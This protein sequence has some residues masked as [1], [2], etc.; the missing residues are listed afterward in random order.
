M[1]VV[2]DFKRERLRLERTRG[3]ISSSSSSSLSRC[4]GTEP[5]AGHTS[6][7]R[8]VAER[9]LV[10][11]SLCGRCSPW[12]FVLVARPSHPSRSPR[13]SAVVAGREAAGQN[14]GRTIGGKLAAYSPINERN[15]SFLLPSLSRVIT[16]NLSSSASP[17]PSRFD[18]AI[19][20][21]PPPRNA[22]HPQGPRGWGCGRIATT[23]SRPLIVTRRTTECPGDRCQFLQVRL[24]VIAQRERLTFSGFLSLSLFLWLYLSISSLHLSIFFLSFLFLSLYYSLICLSPYL[25]SPSL[26][27]FIFYSLSI[28]IY[29]HILYLFLSSF[30]PFLLYV[31]NS[32]LF[33]NFHQIV[34]DDLRT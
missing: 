12:P 34:V 1:C 31:S 7:Y 28:Y 19:A 15:R 33:S 29:V 13:R 2:V 16:C 24:R 23:A 21:S 11:L 9:A 4:L 30:L 3:R 5:V 25:F 10:S 6:L 17:C 8:V 18:V 32:Q 26:L 22:R 20:S 27:I 14:S